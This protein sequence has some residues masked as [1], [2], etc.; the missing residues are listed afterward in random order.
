MQ[1]NAEE[2]EI[3]ENFEE[4]YDVQR[5]ID[6]MPYDE[7]DEAG[8]PHRVMRGGKAM[9]F[10][11]AL[12]GAAALEFMGHEP[13]LADM[14]TSNDDDHVTAIYWISGLIGAV[15]KSNFTTLRFRKPVYKSLREL[16]MSY[17][18]LFQHTR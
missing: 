3:L 9:C 17:F 10:E 1:W 7:S 12:F 6:R 13:L 14:R 11:G 15:A 2:L 16:I 8:S 5:F 18:D 4:P